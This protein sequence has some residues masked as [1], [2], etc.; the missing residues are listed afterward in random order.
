[1]GGAM[2]HT[3]THPH[4][5]TRI[6]ILHIPHY[7]LQNTLVILIIGINCVMLVSDFTQGDVCVA[8]LTYLYTS[9]VLS[10]TYYNGVYKNYTKLVSLSDAF[11]VA[12]FVPMNN[13]VT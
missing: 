6:D 1:M 3:L 9:R 12:S 2:L 11:S 5:H 4:T 7:S 13:C 10:R 8:L